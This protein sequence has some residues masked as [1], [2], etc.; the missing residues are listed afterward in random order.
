MLQGFSDPDLLQG[1]LDTS[2]PTLSRSSWQVL[3]A[4]SEV[5]SWERWT[6]DVA[7][8][9]LEGDPQER[10]LWARIPKDARELIGVPPGTLM[11][12]IK[13]LYGQ[14]DAPRQR[15]AVAR[16]RLL[17]LGFQAHPLDQ[18][19]YMFFDENKV[20]T[21]M[22]G[23][24]VDD[25]FRCGLATSTTYSKLIEQLKTSFN[26]KH[27]TAEGER[28]LE[29]CGCQLTRTATESVMT[30]TDYLKTIKP[31]TCADNEA[32]RELN[33]KEQS[34]LRALLGALQWPATQTS[35]HLCASVSLLCGE[36]TTST[37]NVAQQANKTL[38]FARTTMTPAWCSVPW[39]ARWMTYVWWA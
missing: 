1:Q 4:L 25:L 29:F 27:W 24:H 31:M 18:C 21:A 22:V 35:P 11:R 9:F 20:L 38:R 30:Q 36:V 14:A 26:F 32:E 17:Q 19:L 5:L 13:P 28:P 33:S 2:S 6:A 15:F 3:I 39:V 34:A 7:T 23:I 10:V 12:L 8:A 16:R 37:V